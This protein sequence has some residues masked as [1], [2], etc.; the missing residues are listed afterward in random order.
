MHSLGIVR[1]ACIEALGAQE[2]GQET[3]L[4]DYCSI[5]DPRTV[6]AMANQLETRSAAMS[7]QEVEALGRLVQDLTGY[8]K[9]NADLAPD[10]MRDDLLLEARRLLSAAGL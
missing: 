8:I 5:A 4:K 7:E 10:P 1:Y 6:L 9:R 2:H 3:W